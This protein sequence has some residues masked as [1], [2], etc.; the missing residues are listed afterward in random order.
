MWNS[1]NDREC[2]E[3]VC[4]ACGASISRT[5]AREYDK[6]GDRWDRHGKEFEHLCKACYRGLCHQPRDELEDLLVEIEDDDPVDR[7]EFLSRYV[8][9][10]E[11][12][13]GSRRGR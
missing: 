4:I 12:R 9:A 2:E 5:E 10:V 6:Q 8:G 1:R 11:E 7:A 13:Y 3:V